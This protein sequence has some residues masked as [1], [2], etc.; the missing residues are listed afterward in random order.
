MLGCQD[1]SE[2]HPLIS[3]IGNVI[4]LL[5]KRDGMTNSEAEEF[6]AFNIG[7]AKVGEQT[8]LFALAI[9]D[10]HKKTMWKQ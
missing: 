10:V 7:S 3:D 8:P 4:Y 6:F 9:K 5:Q 2:S 1:G